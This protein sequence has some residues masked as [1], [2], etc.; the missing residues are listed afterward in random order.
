M[1]VRRPHPIRAGVAALIAASTASCRDA[2]IDPRCSPY[3]H[4]STYGWCMADAVHALT[5][6]SRLDAHCAQAAPYTRECR[7]RFVARFVPDMRVDRPT[8]LRW[9]G[10]GDD[11]RLEVIEARPEPDIHPQLQLCDAEAGRF[12]A[13]CATHALQRWATGTPST[14]DIDALVA[15]PVA[16]PQLVG[17]W[18]GAAVACRQVGRCPAH[19]PTAS[20][21]AEGASLMQRSP[22]RCPQP[23]HAQP[24]R[25]LAAPGSP[26]PRAAG[27]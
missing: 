25:G 17:G 22:E 7:H 6:P 13:D 3:A 11:C 15:N 27:G 23:A 9:C 4:T 24:A 16:D 1:H 10:D 2:A 5:D 21:C 18:I 20:A 14:T 26:P 8:L 19:G 12:A